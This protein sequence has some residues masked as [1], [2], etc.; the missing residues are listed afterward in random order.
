MKNLHLNIGFRQIIA[1][2]YILGLVVKGFGKIQNMKKKKRKKIDK[3]PE[4]V[5]G[6]H[7]AYKLIYIYVFVDIPT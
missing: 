3:I 5:I 4:R 2:A 7:R 6:A 1:I